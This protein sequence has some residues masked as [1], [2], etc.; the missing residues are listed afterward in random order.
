MDT[1]FFFIILFIVAFLYA[2]V[3]HGG[4]SGYLALMALYG[5]APQEM[6]PTALF[7]N[8]FVSL[9]A[10]IQYYRGNHFKKE[11]FIPIALASIP[12][13]FLGGMLS[14]DDHLYKKIL[15]ILLLLPIVRF[16]F[17]KNVEDDRLVPPVKWISI[18]LGAFIGLLSGMIGI[19][20]GIILSPILILLLWTNQKQTAA[21]SAAFI[22]VN[23]LAGLGGMLT[24]GITLTSNM[25]LYI[26][27]AFSGGLL[28]AYLGSKKF[29]QDVLKYVLA[30]VLLVAAYKLLFTSA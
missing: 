13:A 1:E 6:K 9:T 19:G 3:G 22:F 11:I 21:I 24:Q 29:N 23:S 8:L 12:F 27:V 20:G 17:F 7:L 14:I 16:F 5:V 28:G 25:I 4:A 30:T 2:S 18:L 15:G 26:V 10:F